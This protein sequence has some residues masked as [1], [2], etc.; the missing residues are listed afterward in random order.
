MYRPLVDGNFQDES[1]RAVK[2]RVI[3]DYS[4]HVGF[5]DKSDRMVNSYGIGQRNSFSTM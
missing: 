3:E 2:P 4:A 5:A 1:G